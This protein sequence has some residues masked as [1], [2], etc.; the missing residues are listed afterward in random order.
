MIVDVCSNYG[1]VHREYTLDISPILVPGIKFAVKLESRHEASALIA[2]MKLKF[3]NKC[4]YWSAEAPMWDVYLAENEGGVV[5]FP[6][7]NNAED[8]YIAWCSVDYAIK[9]GYTVV[10]FSD[11]L[12]QDEPLNEDTQ[13]ISGLFDLFRIK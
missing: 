4:K 5:Y 8:T 2:M 7:L 11:L 13:D 6:D 10:N 9:H 1:V 12:Y 3:P